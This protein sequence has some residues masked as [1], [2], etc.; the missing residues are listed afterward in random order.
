MTLKMLA[1]KFI[2][3]HLELKSNYLGVFIRFSEI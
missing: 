2:D 1:G 3:A